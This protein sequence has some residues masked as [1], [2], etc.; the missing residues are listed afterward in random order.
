MRTTRTIVP[1]IML[2]PF[3]VLALFFP[4]GALAALPDI[5]SV[6]DSVAK[7][8]NLIKVGDAI[9]LSPTEINST[10]PYGWFAA[11]AYYPPET[12]DRW[13][14]KSC[15]ADSIKDFQVY[16]YGGDGDK[17]QYCKQDSC[18]NHTSRWLIGT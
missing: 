3:S 11:T 15:Q 10:I 8:A 14:C 4:L 16:E 12:R 7:D 5:S 2:F 6:V 9:L 17:E 18:H 13:Q 1:L